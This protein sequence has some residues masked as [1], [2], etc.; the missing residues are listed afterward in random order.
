MTPNARFKNSTSGFVT[1]L[2]EAYVRAD[3]FN[4]RRIEQAFPHF[5]ELNLAEVDFSKVELQTAASYADFH[6]GKPYGTDDRVIDPIAERDYFPPEKL[7]PL[8]RPV[9][10]DQ[11]F[12]QPPHPVDAV[13]DVMKSEGLEVNPLI[14]EELRAQLNQAMVE[15]KLLEKYM[16]HVLYYEGIHFLDRIN[17]KEDCVH[18][19]P[20]DIEVLHA[21]RDTI[22]AN[23]K[24]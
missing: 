24:E 1:A 20:G 9:P 12:Y 16:R 17:E 19:T 18:F 21:V 10:A 23:P 3:S 13:V 11:H 5:F 14:T 6:L 4:S 8:P 2:Y 7:R 22:T 15:L